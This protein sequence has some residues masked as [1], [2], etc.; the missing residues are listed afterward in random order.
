MDRSH[1]PDDRT[2]V[3]VWVVTDD[4]GAWLDFV[5][6]AFDG[7]EIARIRTDDGIVGHGEIRVGDSVLLAFDRRPEWP[8]MPRLLR[9]WVPD[10]ALAVE[11]ALERG[12]ELV[13]AVQANAFGQRAGRVRDPFGNVW[14]VTQQ[15]ETVPEDVMWQRLQE[16]GC[17]AIMQDAQE[18]LDRA[19]AGTE[20]GRSSAPRR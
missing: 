14:W 16:P 3:E 5:A 18:S 9:V 10:A 13:T 20:S 15:V 6:H 19:L 12:A 11:R 8:V 7:E 1:I 2:S 17:A 4:T